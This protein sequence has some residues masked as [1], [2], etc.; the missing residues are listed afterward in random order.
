M[1][2]EKR[3]MAYNLERNKGKVSDIKQNIDTKQNEF[4]DLEKNKDELLEA[5]IEIQNSN[6]DENVQETLMDQINQALEANAEKGDELADEMNLDAK[7]LED[8]KQETQESV[9]SNITERKNLEK[10]QK[11]LDKFG[12]GNKL[13]NAITELDDNKAQLEDFNQSLIDAGQK[14][15]QISQKLRS[16]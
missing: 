16:L 9:Q 2:E 13:D 4:K 1:L 8:M 14:I 11:L 15:D 3:N 6:I 5:G 7:D 10:K 12:L